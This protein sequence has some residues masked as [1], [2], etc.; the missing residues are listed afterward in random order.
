[1]WELSSQSLHNLKVR[2]LHRG[3]SPSRRSAKKELG[4]RNFSFFVHVVRAGWWD[5]LLR[6]QVQPC[7]QP[8]FLP[9][10]SFEAGAVVKASLKDNQ[11]I[12]FKVPRSHPGCCVGSGR[13]SFALT[14]LW[15][16]KATSPT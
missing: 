10:P 5:E 9:R 4:I 1:M 12:V 2:F 13:D 16:N 6:E 15:S 11:N 8:L 14:L 7:M 3:G